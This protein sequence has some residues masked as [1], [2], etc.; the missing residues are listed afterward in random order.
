MPQR[1]MVGFR[2][3]KTTLPHIRKSDDGDRRPMAARQTSLALCRRTQEGLVRRAIGRSQGRVRLYRSTLQCADRRP[4]VRPWTRTA[5]QFRDGV[6]RDERAEFIGFLEEIFTLLVANT[7]DGSIHQI[8]MDWRHHG[9]DV[10]A[11]RV[12]SKL[13]NLASGTR[14]MPAWDHSIGRSMSSCSCSRAERLLTSTTSSLA[15]TAASARNVWDYAGV[16][17]FRAG[18]LEEL[19]MHPTVKPVALVADAIKDCSKPGHLV[20]DPFAGSGST[21]IAAERTGR[22]ARALKSRTE[23][24]QRG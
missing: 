14:P 20:L 12:Y 21:I 1:A 9:R 2:V 19:T 22:Q 16:N 11:G 13:K 23:A 17:T 8:C 10:V 15:S 7:V 6:R 5:C 4:R 18:R 3:L 24:S